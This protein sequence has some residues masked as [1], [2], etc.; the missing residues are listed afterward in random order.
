[1]TTLESAAFYNCVGLTNLTLPNSLVTIGNTAFYGCTGIIGQI[2]IP[3]SVKSIGSSAFYN[4]SKITSIVYK[5]KTYTS[6]NALVTA[7][8]Q[9]GVAVTASAFTNC[10]KLTT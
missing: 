7:L 4:C 10:S 3:E 5:S 8:T 6:K 2:T 1:M 9:N